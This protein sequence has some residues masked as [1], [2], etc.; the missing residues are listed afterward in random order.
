[1]IR[2]LRA[3]FIVTLIL[4]HT[5]MLLLSPSNFRK[6]NF[7]FRPNTF[8]YHKIVCVMFRMSLKGCFRVVNVMGGSKVFIQESKFP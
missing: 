4:G 7:I 6:A 3:F 8:V 5:K 2:A 1:M